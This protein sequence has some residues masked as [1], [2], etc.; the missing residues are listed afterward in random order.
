VRSQHSLI[1]APPGKKRTAPTQTK[2]TVPF[3]LPTWTFLAHPVQ[4]LN[5]P[6]EQGNRTS[7]FRQRIPSTRTVVWP[8]A[9]AGPAQAV[10]VPRVGDDGAGVGVGALG[11]AS[12]VVAV[13]V[14][15][16]RF[17]FPVVVS[18]DSG[19]GQLG[20]IG[21]KDAL[22]QLVVAVACP[23]RLAC[24]LRQRARAGRGKATGGEDCVGDLLGC[25]EVVLVLRGEVEFCVCFC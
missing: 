20:E 5:Q 15:A 17:P 25:A 4:V 6:H 10:A 23:R 2:S 24:L 16:L 14:L 1:N 18:G 12:Q 11:V 8:R 9:R 13:A 21:G 7:L 19:S 3:I 22:E